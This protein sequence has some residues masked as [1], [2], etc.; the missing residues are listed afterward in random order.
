[1]TLP[2][3]IKIDLNFEALKDILAQ[4]NATAQWYKRSWVAG[5]DGH[6]RNISSMNALT[7]AGVMVLSISSSVTAEICPIITFIG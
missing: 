7:G 5:I 2:L 3:S 4:I 1:M 6:I